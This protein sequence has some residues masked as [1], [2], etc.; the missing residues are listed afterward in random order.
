MYWPI[1]IKFRICKQTSKQTYYCCCLWFSYL[2]PYWLISRNTITFH[3]Y[4]WCSWFWE[5]HSK[6]K[7]KRIISNMQK[8]YRTNTQC[9]QLSW[10]RQETQDIVPYLLLSRLEDEISQIL[11]EVVISSVNLNF[12]QLSSNCFA[13]FELFLC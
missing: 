9:C 10:I 11:A 3:K 1:T 8:V 12:R 5:L 4:F 13:L 6:Q 7:H 2:V